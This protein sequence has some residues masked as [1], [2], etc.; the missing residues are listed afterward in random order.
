VVT[1]PVELRGV[2]VRI[3]SGAGVTDAILEALVCGS[4]EADLRPRPANACVL[5]GT[6]AKWR[7]WYCLAIVFIDGVQEGHGHNNHG[8]MG[9]RRALRRLRLASSCLTQ[10]PL[11]LA[12]R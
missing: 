2:A 12:W 10:K 1:R 4:R 8:S 9:K 3:P 7:G 11:I 6:M 5:G